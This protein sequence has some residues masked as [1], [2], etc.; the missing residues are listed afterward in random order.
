M[1]EQMKHHAARI[2]QVGVR[3][4]VAR[5]SVNIHGERSAPGFIWVNAN[6][7]GEKPM[8]LARLVKGSDYPDGPNGRCTMCTLPKPWC[9]CNEKRAAAKE[10]EEHRQKLEQALVSGDRQA[11]ALLKS[12]DLP[13]ESDLGSWD[14]EHDI[15]NNAF[16]E[17]KSKSKHTWDCAVH[18]AM[19]LTLRSLINVDRIT[20]EHVVSDAFDRLQSLVD[21]REAKRSMLGKLKDRNKSVD[22][23]DDMADQYDR[24]NRVSRKSLR[25]SEHQ[26]DPGYIVHE[27][28]KLADMA[29]EDT[30]GA[31][32]VH[33]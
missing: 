12:T 31:F 21:K 30:L 32:R 23:I 24:G 29:R 19:F 11:V 17:M 25:S 10:Q 3:A 28:R 18:V 27:L 6:S 7:T 1:A 2:I 5:R 33:D 13:G 20:P 26:I 8:P 4:F 16:Q 22:S 9:G 14:A 15:D